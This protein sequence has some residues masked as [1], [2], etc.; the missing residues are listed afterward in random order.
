MTSTPAPAGFR[1]L[2]LGQGLSWFGD[3][4]APIALAV[5]V[6]AGGG[7]ASELGL[8]LA[9]TMAARLAGTLVGGVWADRVSPGRIMVAS[10]AVRAL[11][12]LAIAGYFATGGRGPLTSGLKRLDYE[13]GKA[14]VYDFGA[15]T[16]VG[17]PVFAPKPNGKLDEGWLIAECLDGASRTTFFAL[18][19]A[20]SVGPGPIAKI[21]LE[22]HVPINFHGAWLPA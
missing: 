22:H 19:D 4:F 11:S 3:A 2:A 13:T 1:L 17:E 14:E 10:D 15:R 21:W 8:V 20:A 5:A 12:T 16:V 6:L 7:S 9:A 18:F